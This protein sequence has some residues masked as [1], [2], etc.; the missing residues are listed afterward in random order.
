[1]TVMKHRLVWILIGLPLLLLLLVFG[2]LITVGTTQPGL[3][4]LLALG[5]H[6]S[7][8]Q[9]SV[10]SAQG[11]LSSKFHLSGL[12][13][14]AAG[15]ELVID[16][17]ELQ[18]H[19]TA[20][21]RKEARLHSLRIG[22]VH[23]HLPPGEEAAS[24]KS[25][26]ASLPTFTFPVA[27]HVGQFILEDL[28]IFAADGEEQFTLVQAGAEQLVAQ[29]QELRFDKLAAKNSWMDVQVKGALRTEANY[30][31]QL[32]LLY[33]FDFDGYGPIRGLG[34]LHGDLAKLG[35]ESVLHSPAEAELQGELANLLTELHWQARL[36]SP[37]L[38]LMAINAGWPEQVFDQVEIQGSGSIRTYDLQ[39][40]GRVVSQQ[41]RRPLGLQSELQVGWDGLR[42]HA[43]RL[44]DQQGRLDLSG[45]LD[46]SPA[47]TWDAQVSTED[48][49]PDLVLEELPGALSGSLVSQG[50][51]SDDR[52]ELDVQ[53]ESLEGQLRQYPLNAS[54]RL[55]YHDGILSIP[56]VQAAVGRSTL[57]LQGTAQEK[58]ALELQLRSPDLQELL[59]QL[60]GSL[61]AQ[62]QVQGS[63]EQPQV[64]LD[65]QGEQLVVAD[66]RIETLWA[67]A[68]GVVDGVGKLQAE[69]QA[70]QLHIGAT[71][72][73]QADARFQGSLA[74]HTLTLQAMGKDEQ[75][76]LELAGKKKG[77]GWKGELRRLQLQAPAIGRW[78]QQQAAELELSAHQARIKPFCLQMEDS[79]VCLGGQ[80]QQEEQR[81][82]AS[83][84][85]ANVS[86]AR[87]QQWLPPEIKLDGVL[88][89]ETEVAGQGAQLRAGQLSAATSGLRLNFLYG[90]DS[91]GLP[92]QNLVWQTQSLEAT[93][94]EGQLAAAWYNTL[95][96]G[97]RLDAQI[98][99]AR[100]PIPGADL[101]QAPVQG[102]VELDIRKLTFLNA[103]T[104]QQSKWNGQLRGNFQLGG[105]MAKPLLTGNLDLA[106]GEVL[107]P[108]LG[109]R[110]SPLQVEVDGHDGVL[111]AELQAHS[112]EGQVLVQAEVDLNGQKP[113]ILPVSIQGDSFRVVNQPGFELDVSP[114]I[115][116]RFDE[117][118]INLGGRVDIPHARI[119]TITFESAITPSGDVVVIDDPSYTEAAIRTAMPLYARVLVAVGEDVLINT[120][121]LRGRIG[122]QLQ[123]VLE[124]GRPLAGNGRLNVEEGSFSIYGKRVKIDTGRLLFSGGSL[125][126]PGIDI[127]SEN[128]EDN[129]TAGV[130][131]D[132]FLKTPRIDLYSRP[133]MDQAAIVA[134]LLED[135]NSFGGS[136]RDDVGLVGD[137]AKKMGMGGLVPYLEGIKKIS[138]IDD[139]KLDTK[140]DA[141][142]LVFGSWITPDFYVSYGKSL[143][144]EGGTFN[145]RYTLGK[146]FVLE[147]ESGETQSSGDIKYEFEH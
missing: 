57:H 104:R 113:A 81:W 4:T 94:K 78:Q 39:V 31:L 124:P 136:R 110:L 91:G 112:H 46:W 119:E 28:H 23:L 134:H 129:I 86:L 97:S 107:V 71:L 66:N 130:R 12:R 74:N 32:E 73:E 147:T 53:I 11:R 88:Q 47:L 60:A 90:G 143:T 56:G 133:H 100:F 20:L 93:Y 82:Q 69:V 137:T 37:L 115:Q 14:S 121:G 117:D 138:M 132:G 22:G 123:L 13:Y 144:G 77:E 8:G 76:S 108:E 116:V 83:A 79:A 17:L 72:V 126:N 92:A 36:N 25:Q 2:L 65:L 87:F 80:W 15:T 24:E 18:W 38:A 30:P 131:V 145:T 101:A 59:P 102:T 125:T 40:A 44:D 127:R 106:E 122:G 118:R 142:S 29:G 89:M 26:P 51:W 128:T 84:Q 21:L 111:A 141:A 99:S 19:P 68:Q 114:D 95:D 62:A 41:W 105:S 10:V 45:T 120:Y 1:M 49:S 61:Q 109:L 67:Q 35:V 7:K 5:S 98:S 85:V 33:A 3:Q 55:G 96:D 146:G 50:S 48:L 16:N 42:I 64:V 52:L 139:I 54:G 43:L 135:S 140:T 63:R 103:L 75:L 34:N 70:R 6:L 27:L 58:L 9:V